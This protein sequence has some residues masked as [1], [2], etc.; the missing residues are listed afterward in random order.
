MERHSWA[1]TKDND[2]VNEG[3]SVTADADGDYAAAAAAAADADT[4]AATAADVDAAASD[5]VVNMEYVKLDWK[6]APR[7]EKVEGEQK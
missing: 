5:V 4:N 6:S 3:G 1:L 7:K 2:G